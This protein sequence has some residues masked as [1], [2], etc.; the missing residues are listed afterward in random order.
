MAPQRRPHRGRER[1]VEGMRPWFLEPV[2]ADGSRVSHG[3]TK[4]RL[5]IGRDAQCDLVIDARG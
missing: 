2:A 4:L 3:I 5:R 1:G